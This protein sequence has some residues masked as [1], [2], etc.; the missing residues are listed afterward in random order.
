MC[1][2]NLDM[3]IHHQLL[4]YISNRTDK[5]HYR[6]SHQTAHM[7]W[8]V[9]PQ[10]LCPVALD[11]ILIVSWLC[12][13][14]CRHDFRNT[15]YIHAWIA[16]D[17]SGL[18]STRSEHGLCMYRYCMHAYSQEYIIK[19][20]GECLTHY[21]TVLQPLGGFMTFCSDIHQCG[22]SQLALHLTCKRSWTLP[23][24]RVVTW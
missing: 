14:A 18:Q 21:T 3:C 5:I 15:V 8:T 19:R 24:I 9:A 16:I 13:H 10:H 12:M 1:T 22:I 17:H 2:Y 7:V 6:S 4:V 11:H 23:I 20:E